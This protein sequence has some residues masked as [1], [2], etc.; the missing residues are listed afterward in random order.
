MKKQLPER[1]I[2]EWLISVDKD[3][4]FSIENVLENSIYYPACNTDGS[5]LEAFGGFAHSFVYADPNITKEQ[6]IKRIPKVAG[7]S[8][9]FARDI[10]KEQLC[11]KP[12]NPLRPIPEIDGDPTSELNDAVKVSVPLVSATISCEVRFAPKM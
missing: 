6:L 11:F 12:F 2:P 9:L 7:Y 10:L 8:V 4:E 1:P 5:M 3:S